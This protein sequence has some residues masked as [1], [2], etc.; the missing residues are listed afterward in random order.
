MSERVLRN[1][2]MFD[3]NLFHNLYIIEKQR[4]IGIKTDLINTQLSLKSTE[5]IILMI[6][7]RHYL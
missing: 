6:Y 3:K 1:L 2:T 5:L 7:P 4:S